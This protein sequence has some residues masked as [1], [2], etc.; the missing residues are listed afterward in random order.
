MKKTIILITIILHALVLNASVQAQSKKVQPTTT[1]VFVDKTLSSKSN[2]FIMEKNKKWLIKTLRRNVNRGGDGVILSFIFSNTASAS[3]EFSF[4][5]HAPRK[6]SGHMSPNDKKIADIQYK[7]RLRSAKRKYIKDVVAHAFNYKPSLNG[8]NVVGLIKKLSDISK[9]NPKGRIK[10]I[11][12]SDLVE[13][14][15]FQHL[16]CHKKRV[17]SIGHAQKLAKQDLTRVIKKYHLSK[18]CLK[19]ISQITIV[20]PAKQLD[21]NIAFTT[22]PTYWKFILQSLGA[23]NISFH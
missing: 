16:N 20:F 19:N 14:S 17:S 10:A 13:C 18:N 23:R 5:F 8:T 7:S 2:P 11:V 15:S 4:S 6:R 9:A 3:N 1:V 12:L 22:L 21:G